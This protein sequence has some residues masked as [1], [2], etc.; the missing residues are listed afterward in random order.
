MRHLNCQSLGLVASAAL[1][2]IMLQTMSSATA[3]DAQL[4]RLKSEA[5]Q[6]VDLPARKD[7]I[8]EHRSAAQERARD[9]KSIVDERVAA[10]T[11]I[12]E[13]AAT[14]EVSEVE[15][16]LSTA[17]QNILM[18][19]AEADS[20]AIAQTANQVGE[21]ALNGL[22]QAP[23]QVLSE[24]QLD[25]LVVAAAHAATIT[26]Q[27]V[28]KLLR[29]GAL[30]IQAYEGLDAEEITA[31]I[32]AIG[33]A[34]LD[35]QS[36]VQSRRP[37]AEAAE[38][39]PVDSVIVVLKRGSG[40]PGDVAMSVAADV[41]GRVGFLYTHAIQ[42]FSLHV[43]AAAC[44]RIERNP[45]VEF[46]DADG[47]V[48]LNA[49]TVPTGV[50]R[51][52]ADYGLINIDEDDD[53]RVDVDVAVLDT[54]IDID[55][56]DLNVAGGTNCLYVTGVLPRFRTSYCEDAETGDDDHYHGTHVAGTIGA[57]DNETGVVGIAP[58]ARLWAVKVLDETGGGLFSGIIAG[59]DW[60][61][62]RGD[63]EVINL[64]L[65]GPGSSRAMDSAVASAVDAGVTVIAAAGNDSADAAQYTPA[66]SPGAITVSAI[67][68]FDGAAGGSAAPTCTADIDDSLANFSNYGSA[69]DMAAPGT[70]IYSTVPL[71]RGGYAVISGTSMAAPHVAGAAAILAS[72]PGW[73]PE[74][75]RA[76]L[77]RTGNFDWTEDR[78]SDPKEPL[79]DLGSFAPTL[80]PNGTG[81]SDRI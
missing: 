60:V 77:L 57:L 53:Y 19:L 56:P 50:R 9:L 48:Q 73:T 49:Q 67:A 69:V 10:R 68:D 6:R 64:S 32:N 47:E 75:I 54:G 70:C 66:N 59:I 41:G 46:C 4:G 43:P 63:I 2:A 13:R 55:H 65:G 44:D 74:S 23:G 62:A 37:L 38:F 17:Q 27:D 72:T 14:V 7:S 42:G 24:D 21:A 26:A 20:A 28:D 1:G 33:A 29:Q 81:D 8:N 76:E 18:A 34:A 22:E 58:G 80:Q 30:A 36:E 71:E 11:E 5:Q 40:P 3:A 52:F 45:S 12:F 51:S 78:K 35:I 25:T 16:R 79:L 61:V 39:Q 31:S 15:A